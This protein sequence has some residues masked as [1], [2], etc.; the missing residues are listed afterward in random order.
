MDKTH[1]LNPITGG[2]TPR[3]PKS[4]SEVTN[5]E[6]ALLYQLSLLDTTAPVFAEIGRSLCDP[7][8]KLLETDGGGG[9]PV[10]VGTKGSGVEVG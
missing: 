3:V 4:W 2:Q 8:P 6:S 10:P 1:G 9:T 5:T 7:S